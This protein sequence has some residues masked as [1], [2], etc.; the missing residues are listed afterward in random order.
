LLGG[1]ELPHLDVDRI[2]RGRLVKFPRL[3]LELVQRL[4]QAGKA[5]PLDPRAVTDRELPAQERCS[6][7]T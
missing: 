4:F 5:R 7:G 3:A 2:P 6:I 1:L